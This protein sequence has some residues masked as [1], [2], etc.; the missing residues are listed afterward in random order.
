MVPFEKYFNVSP[1]FQ[2]PES[3][4]IEAIVIHDTIR[5]CDFMKKCLNKTKEKYSKLTKASD[6]DVTNENIHMWGDLANNLPQPLLSKQKSE[7]NDAFEPKPTELPGYTQVH[8]SI[9]AQP[10]SDARQHSAPSTQARVYSRT[11]TQRKHHMT[12]AQQL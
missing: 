3:I 10:R 11:V 1:V 2:L 6:L 8:R 4:I 5:F 7:S 9:V 12:D